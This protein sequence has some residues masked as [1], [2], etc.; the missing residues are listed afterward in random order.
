MRPFRILCLCVLGTSVLACGR[1]RGAPA[2]FAKAPVI[3]ISI[4]TVR[5]DRL[6]MFG[7][8]NVETPH[9]DAFRNDAV[10]F[11]NAYSH[12]PLTLPSHAALLTGKLPHENGVRDNIGYSLEKTSSSLPQ[13]MKAR[14][15]ETGAAVSAY[16]LRGETGLRPLFDWY[17]D[18]IPFVPGT[19]AGS[20]QRAGSATID[21]ALQ[22]IEP[23]REKPFFFLLHL[24]EPHTPYE[25]PDAFRSAAASAY[26]G[27]IA[28]VDTLV[29]R[30]IEH[31]KSAQLYDRAIIVLLSDHGE[32]LGEHSEREHGI[33]VYRSTIHVPLMM[34][35]PKQSAAGATVDRAV[36]LIDVAPTLVELTG[37]ASPSDFH[38]LSLARQATPPRRIYSESVYG[39]LHLG[40]SDLRSLVDEQHHFIEAPRPEL[41]D[42]ASDPNE[43]RNVLADNRR[44]YA[45]FRDEM[46]RVPREVNAPTKVSAE[47]AAKLAALGY[48]TAGSTSAGSELPDPK[49]RIG[50][51]ALYD[52][53]IAML[54]ERQT[55]R[56]I[57]T[58][59][60]LLA[61][62]PRFGDAQLQ[63]AGA[64]EATGQY[65]E[66]EAVYREALRQ[67][68]A[69][70][71][72]VA[73]ALGAIYL[74]L[75]RYDDA[76]KHADLALAS[77]PG[78]AHLLLGR[79]ALARGD[80]RGAERHAREASRDGHYRSSAALLS[81]EVFVQ[82]RNPAKALEVLDAERKVPIRSLEL[83]RGD[84]LMRL[85]RPAEAE[86]AFREEIRLF[87][88]NRDAY[89]SLAGV[90]ALQGRVADTQATLQS[91]VTANPTPSSYALAAKTLDALGRTQEANEWR[92]RGA[93]IQ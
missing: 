47:E 1:E 79:I 63:L 50:E 2:T 44:V 43:V 22:W 23:R 25:P 56:A 41:Y 93:T 45:S 29:G 35:L 77:N 34:K 64:Y 51:L 57:E 16:V 19:A 49:D 76:A 61:K 24:F 92:R 15:Y 54:R 18:S 6:P 80:V 59:R 62:N 30:F 39:R 36:G 52:D 85:G 69:L 86:A 21:V 84:A 9:L 46:S 73:V 32:G 26:D 88:D 81:A 71:E 68:P 33:F 37:G 58:L 7:Y 38:G 65:R 12:V 14:G 53:A 82:E 78:G 48:L 83:R 60:T 42:L 20:I 90:Y 10:L 74:N 66:A 75:G 72:Q 17:E 67:N 40:W 70:I 91:M 87:P 89:T 8:R 13:E 28:Y 55:T 4:D 3:I 5:A 11:R 27:E 31:L